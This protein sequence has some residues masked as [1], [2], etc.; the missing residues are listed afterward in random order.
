MKLARVIGNVVCTTKDPRLAG[1]K[2]LLISEIDDAGHR[3]GEPLAALDAVGVGEGETV[4]FV[5]SK[6]ASFPFDPEEVPTDACVVG[7]V[8]EINLSPEASET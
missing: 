7:V 8:D 6:E 4:F 2:I 1:R 3:K 5:T